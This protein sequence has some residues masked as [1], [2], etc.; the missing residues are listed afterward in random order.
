MSASRMA[1]APG[2][3]VSRALNYPEKLVYTQAAQLLID[4]TIIAF[5]LATAYFV[6]FDGLP[7][8]AFLKQGLFILP[9]VVVLYLGVNFAFRIYSFVWRFTGV[10]EVFWIACSVGASGLIMFLARLL[11]FEDQYVSMRVP[12]GVLALHPTLAGM[13]MICVRGL[14]RLQYQRGRRKNGANG[15][16]VGKRV[17]LVGA[18]EA[19]VRLAQELAERDDFRMIGFVDDD[20]R[21]IGRRINGLQVLGSTTEIESLVRAKAIDKVV[22]SMPSA[23]QFRVREIAR[24]CREIPVKVFTVPP[25][26]EILLGRVA[27]SSL[28]PVQMSDLLGRAAVVHD[29]KD[30]NLVRCYRGKRIM[31][32]GAGG[33]IGSELARQLRF[34]KPA[35]LIL[36]DKDENGVYETALEVREDFAGKVHEVVADI[37][38]VGRLGR[39]F[40]RT[41]PEVIFHAAAFKHVPMMEKHPWEA[42][43]NNVVGTRNLVE[44]A[45]VCKVQ[46]FVLISTDKAV[47]PTSVMGASKR[48]AE[49]VVQQA[50]SQNGC[51]YC[52]VRFGNVLGSR[53][54]VVPLFQKR[55]Q[56][57]KPLQ[58]T[59]PEIRRYFMTIPEAVQLVIQAGSLGKRGEIFVLDMGDPVKILDLANELI[60]LSGLIPGQDIKIEFTGLRPGEKLYEELLVGEG[61][62]STKYPKIFVEQLIDGAWQA[63]ETRFEEL[64]R[65][66]IREDVE[67]IYRLL[68]EMGIGYHRPSRDI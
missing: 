59:H 67:T 37:Q 49:M 55:I 16:S 27:I 52:A 68:K 9:Y 14:R 51:S 29:L 22:L 18:G 57:G 31:V 11:V 62:R 50:A 24:R 58:V 39:V 20:P 32:T 38:N 65:A 44:L 23:P 13:G 45:Q 41:R 12:Y 43:L 53:A 61:S 15:N 36:L 4:A 35:E 54:S 40:S 2:R 10:R 8:R 1:L 25:V 48:L 28:R 63:L 66:A 17:L 19:G 3:M 42:I 26:S 46:T 56:Q 30:F 47:N 60:E 7:P 34:F 21:K 5:A 6:R 33:S 64:K